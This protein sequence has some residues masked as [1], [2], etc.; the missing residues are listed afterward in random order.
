[1]RGALPDITVFTRTTSVVALCEIRP[2]YQSV[3]ISAASSGRSQVDGVYHIVQ[4]N[5]VGLEVATTCER[6]GRGL[7]FASHAVAASETNN[8]ADCLKGGVL[9]CTEDIPG[10]LGDVLSA[11]EPGREDETLHV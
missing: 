8:T 11:D 5:L 6:R 9:A 4:T 10:E 7:S 2:L 3:Q 1:L